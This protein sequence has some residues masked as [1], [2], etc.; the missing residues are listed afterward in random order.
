MWKK[1]NPSAL[2][3]RWYTS[4][5]AKENSMEVFLKVDLL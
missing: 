2:S 3:V 5:V 1:K 4:A